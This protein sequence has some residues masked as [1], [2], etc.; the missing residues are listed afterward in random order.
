MEP[1]QSATPRISFWILSKEDES[2][3]VSETDVLFQYPFSVKFTSQAH[4]GDYAGVFNEGDADNSASWIF[5][6]KI[7][8][9]F[10]G[11]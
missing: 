5:M 7:T 9:K 2:S 10:S 1:R 11:G 4:I 8:L 6:K 3:V